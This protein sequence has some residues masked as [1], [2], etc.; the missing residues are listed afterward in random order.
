MRHD[1]LQTVKHLSVHDTKTLSQKVSK[2]FA[3][4]GEL[5]DSALSYEN[6]KGARHKI[7]TKDKLLDE[8]ADVMLVAMSIAY[9]L[10]YEDEDINSMLADKTFHWTNRNDQD[11]SDGKYP[12][13]I[14][15]TVSPRFGDEA[16]KFAAY[17]KTSTVNIKPIILDLGKDIPQQFTTSSVVHGTYHEAVYRAK[18]LAA[19]LE[20]DGYKVSRQK[21]E[22]VPWHPIVTSGWTDINWN[23]TYFES[24][25]TFLIEKKKVEGLRKAALKEGLHISR[26]ALK[27]DVDGYT[28]IMGTFRTNDKKFFDHE[29]KFSVALMHISSDYEYI[30][31]IS[32]FALYDTNQ[33]LDNKWLG[34]QA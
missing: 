9:S 7:I 10:G 6:A 19:Q 3:E 8:V 31:T 23:N 24:H 14:H 15:L 26:N 13:E 21:I 12:F 1:I 16:E 27:S 17:C 5:A 22:T 18:R 11:K 34:I 32:E 2:L 30:K 20:S 28:K 4:G 25:V 29:T 33:A